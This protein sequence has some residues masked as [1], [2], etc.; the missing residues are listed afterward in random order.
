MAYHKKKAAE[1]Y[2]ARDV[3]RALHHLEAA[4][5]LSPG[6]QD[7]VV[8]KGYCLHL[9]GRYPEAL[10]TFNEVLK[11]N[12]NQA[13]ALSHRGAVYLTLEEPDKALADFDGACKLSPPQS[14]A[15]T[16]RGI[17]NYQLGHYELAVKDLTAAVKLAPKNGNAYLH[18][19]L[20]HSALKQWA[21]A[22][23]PPQRQPPAH[24]AG[25]A[26]AADRP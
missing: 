15:F 4:A 18:R 1:A 14:K 11:R 23:R 16:G 19:G 24:R 20:C 7:L 26:G 9:L 13:A 3:G 6:D 8:Q 22:R 2:G 17:A 10:A 21:A 5:R 25:A 12:P